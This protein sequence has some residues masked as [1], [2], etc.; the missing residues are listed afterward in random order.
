M[1][2]GIF[3]C[4]ISSMF[5]SCYQ[6]E[7]AKKKEAAFIVTFA[8]REQEIAE[9]KV[10]LLFVPFPPPPIFWL[11][12]LLVKIWLTWILWF[13]VAFPF[14]NIFIRKEISSFEPH[15]R[16][17]FVMVH[18]AWVHQGTSTREWELLIASFNP[19]YVFTVM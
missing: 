11:M 3:S 1:W 17:S 15:V 16:D 4:M 18:F 8:K 9:L 5:Y 13:H 6:L 19:S 12:C 2:E 10:R 14:G 7:K